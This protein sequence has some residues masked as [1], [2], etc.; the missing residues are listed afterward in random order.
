MIQKWG[1]RGTASTL[2]PYSS[3][4][5]YTAS[6]ITP[7]ERYALGVVDY[8]LKPTDPEELHQKINQILALRRRIIPRRT[9]S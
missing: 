9:A 2:C 4:S 6:L 8:L 7:A 5:L 3:S 1:K